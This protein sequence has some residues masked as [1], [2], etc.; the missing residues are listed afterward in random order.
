MKTHSLFSLA[1]G[2]IKI[3]SRWRVSGCGIGT[4]DVEV[5]G[6]EG[7]GVSLVNCYLAADVRRPTVREALDHHLVAAHLESDPARKRE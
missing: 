2:M 1:G 6:C 4:A 3:F 5:D 7:G